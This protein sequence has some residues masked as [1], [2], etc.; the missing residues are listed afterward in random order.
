MTRK[1][2][3]NHPSF[4]Y[5]RYPYIYLSVCLSIH[6]FIYP[7]IYYSLSFPLSEVRSGIL[8]HRIP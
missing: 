8:F 1:T 4:F 2:E 5:I 6:L 3:Q 7:Y